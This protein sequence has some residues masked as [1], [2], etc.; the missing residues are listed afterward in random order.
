MYHY[1][2]DKEYLSR[3]RGLCGEIMQNLCHRLKEECDI[4]ASFYMVGSGARNLIMQNGNEPI[5]LDYNLE[6][7]RCENYDDCKTIKETVRKAFNQTLC[8][9]GWGD[10]EDSRSSLTT[11]KRFFKK[12]NQTEFY[13]DLCIVTEDTDGYY[14]RL[15]HDKTG[16]S[17]YDRYFWNQAP[18]SKNIRKKAKKIKDFGEWLSVRDEYER[19]KNL[20]LRRND[21]DHPSFI[22]YV[23]AVNNVYN[24]IIK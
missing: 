21:R 24:S 15:I 12:G 2:D 11:E 4:G 18:D 23:E 22:C 7:I 14:H 5:D 1:L 6:I 17:Y 20:Y 19:L 3:V 8:E 13:I 9:F 16:F 10:C